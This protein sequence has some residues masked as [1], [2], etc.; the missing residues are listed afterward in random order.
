VWYRDI[1]HRVTLLVLLVTRLSTLP[2][3]YTKWA[4]LEREEV[5]GGAGKVLNH[6]ERVTGSA[7]ACVSGALT[8]Q[9]SGVTKVCAR[10]GVSA[11]P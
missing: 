5:G 10:N 7:V 3:S 6:L 4:V 1:L 2:L 8:V 9:G 11:A